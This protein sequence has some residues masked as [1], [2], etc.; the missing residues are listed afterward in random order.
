MTN[1]VPKTWV[2]EE[3]LKYG[4]YECWIKFYHIGWFFKVEHTK[5]SADLWKIIKIWWK[6]LPKKWRKALFNLHPKFG[7]RE[8]TRSTTNFAFTAICIEIISVLHVVHIHRKTITRKKCGFIFLLYD[9][10]N[11]ILKNI[12]KKSCLSTQE[13]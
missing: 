12:Q 11:F 8:L 1:R 7:F 3:P 10:L 5:G 4:F 9:F 2:L 6:K 13:K